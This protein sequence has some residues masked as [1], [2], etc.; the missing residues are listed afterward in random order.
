MCIS[1]RV[2]RGIG[3]SGYRGR[4]YGHNAI[5]WPRKINGKLFTFPCAGFRFRF[6]FRFLLWFSFS[7][8]VLF[9]HI[10]NRWRKHFPDAF[11]FCCRL[12][13]SF[14]RFSLSFFAEI[15]IPFFEGFPFFFFLSTHAIKIVTAKA[16]I[17]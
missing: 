16:Q 6:R 1:K 14:G 3:V 8:P 13:K 5:Y 9:S 7:C 11:Q 4:D 2:Y 17:N 12:V 10:E 15:F